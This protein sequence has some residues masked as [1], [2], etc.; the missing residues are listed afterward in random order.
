MPAS[1][2]FP[3]VNWDCASPRSN[4]VMHTHYN[5]RNMGQRSKQSLLVLAGI[6]EPRQSWSRVVGTLMNQKQQ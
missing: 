5:K 6:S 2:P 1:M 3:L 4:H